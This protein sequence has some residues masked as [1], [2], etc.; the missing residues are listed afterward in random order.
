MRMADLLESFIRDGDSIT[1]VDVLHLRDYMG[2]L[3]MQRD[4]RIEKAGNTDRVGAIPDASRRARWD[5]TCL[6][7]ESATIWVLRLIDPLLPA[8]CNQ[9]SINRDRGNAMNKQEHNVHNDTKDF[10]DGITY[11]YLWPF[12]EIG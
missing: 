3:H 1:L 9:G 2:R 7:E 10:A 8:A 5:A 12:V 6:T 4:A 11:C